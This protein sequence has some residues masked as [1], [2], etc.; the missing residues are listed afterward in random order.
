MVANSKA[1]ELFRAQA[2][3]L[4]A[5]SARMSELADELDPPSAEDL[6]DREIRADD[7]AMWTLFIRVYHVVMSKPGISTSKIAACMGLPGNYPAANSNHFTAQILDWLMHKGL[8]YRV[9]N[10]KPYE[11]M[12]NPV[13]KEHQNLRLVKG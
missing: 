8:V 7:D 5:A 10:K 1:A 3:E 6:I 4:A 2:S 9:S 13:P 11:W 12:A